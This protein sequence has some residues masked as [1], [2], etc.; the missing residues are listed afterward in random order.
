MP[1]NTL[2]VDFDWT[3]HGTVTAD[4][5]TVRFESAPRTP[6]IYRIDLD[7]AYTYIGEAGSLARRF[8]GYRSPGGSPD[9]LA[10]RTNR[11]VQRTILD[12]LT[13]GRIVAV[14]ICTSATITTTD[15]PGVLALDNKAHRLL[16]EAAAMILAKRDGWT[17][18]NLHRH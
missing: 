17:L 7:A 10:P 8:A 16:V 9:T 4:A 2:V 5:G 12:A 1:G 13:D 6:G 18:E 3:P 15:G 11:R 14:W